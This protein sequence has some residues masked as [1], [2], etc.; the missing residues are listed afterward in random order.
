M[1]VTQAAVCLSAPEMHHCFHLNCDPARDN[2]YTATREYACV[3]V[4]TSRQHGCP[5][6]D[7]WSN[8]ALV[9][10]WIEHLIESLNDNLT[11]CTDR[12]CTYFCI[13]NLT[14]PELSVRSCQSLTS[15]GFDYYQTTELS[16]SGVA[17]ESSTS[18]SA[19]LCSRKVLSPDQ[20]PWC[21]FVHVHV[22]LRPP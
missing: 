22:W 15:T 7:G 21:W 8:D 6:K 3:C 20:L 19:Y 16:C 11:D 1:T 2:C 4:Y 17:K 9:M 5:S 12:I 18:C 13:S 14:S 10:K